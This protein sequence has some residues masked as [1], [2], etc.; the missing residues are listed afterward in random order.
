MTDNNIKPTK[1]VDHSIPFAS[2]RWA[3]AAHY[4]DLAAQAEQ[5]GHF[6]MAIMHRETAAEIRRGTGAPRA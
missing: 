3:E 2:L 4:D 6:R 1:P 5:W